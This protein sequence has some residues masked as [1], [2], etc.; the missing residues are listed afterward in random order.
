MRKHFAIE[1]LQLNSQ[2]RE[3]CI[4]NILIVSFDKSTHFKPQTASVTPF[5]EPM[6]A[7]SHFLMLAFKSNND[8][9]EPIL[10]VPCIKLLKLV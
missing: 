8:L 6:P 10:Y 5:R 2:L 1:L 9:I 3:K 7:V 4:P